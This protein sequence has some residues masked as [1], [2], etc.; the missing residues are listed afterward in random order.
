M[1]SRFTPRLPT[2]AHPLHTPLCHGSLFLV[3]C[4]VSHCQ[5]AAVQRQQCISFF[6]FC[7]SIC[8]PQTIIRHPPH[9]FHRD[10]LS[11]MMIPSPLTS[12]F[13]W[14]SHLTSERRPPKA[15]TLS[16]SLIFDGSHV[17]APSKRTSRGNR[18]PATRRLLWI[19][20]ESRRQDLGAREG[21][22]AGG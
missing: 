2:G 3:G 19:H 15:K 11:S 9:T 5:L 13:G 4:C 6:F 12:T 22:A 7:R 16:L 14:L 17:G 10:H 8:Y 20:G 1:V 21:K 18:E